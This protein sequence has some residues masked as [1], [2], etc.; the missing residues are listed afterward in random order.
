M[1]RLL[2]IVFVFSALWLS[3]CSSELPVDSE[4]SANVPPGQVKA[5]VT[6]TVEFL[7]EHQEILDEQEKRC[8]DLSQTEALK[9]TVCQNVN[10][11][12]RSRLAD[13]YLDKG[14]PPKKLLSLPAPN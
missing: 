12:K 4:A 2:S 9:D 11:A 8:K 14:P 5:T 13:G 3:A 10:L 1:M 7:A 6:L